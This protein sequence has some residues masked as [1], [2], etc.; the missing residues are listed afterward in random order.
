M[1]YRLEKS[2]RSFMGDAGKVTATG[3]L[4]PITADRRSPDAALHPQVAADQKGMQS[5]GIQAET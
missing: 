3:G 2:P 5:P 1:I 4:P